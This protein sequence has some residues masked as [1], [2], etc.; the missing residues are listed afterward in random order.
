MHVDWNFYILFLL[1]K[2]DEG[3]YCEYELKN[4]WPYHPTQKFYLYHY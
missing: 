3:D 4:M 1:E 2:T